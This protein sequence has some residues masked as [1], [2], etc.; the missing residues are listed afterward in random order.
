LAFCLEDGSTLLSESADA[1][2]LPATLVIS[3][4]RMTNPARPETFRAN[5]TPTQAQ[6]PQAYTAPPPPRW[7]PLPIPQ[8]RPTST[9][10]RGRG[11][12][13]T[14]LVCAISAFLLLAFCII[15][16]ASGVDESLIGGIFIF[17]AVLALF[18][19]VLGIVA[20]VRTSR[21]ANPQNS[22]VMAV[23]ALVLN[24]IYLLIAVIFLILGAIASSR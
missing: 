6:P 16:G 1:S 3:D 5:P 19:A 17:S 21:D 4:P 14:S 15:G 23:V 9:A 18:G 20:A 22:K 11:A 8:A 12:A 13:I 24:G 2:D 10:R 7:P